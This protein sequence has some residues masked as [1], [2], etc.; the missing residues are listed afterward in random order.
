[1]QPRGGRWLFQIDENRNHFGFAEYDK[2]S[3]DSSATALIMDKPSP[4]FAVSIDPKDCGIIGNPNV[5]KVNHLST[6]GQ[7]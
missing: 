6:I 1:V 7:V 4:A 3:T 2:A 5:G